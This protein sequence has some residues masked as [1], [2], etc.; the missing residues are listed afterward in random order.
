MKEKEVAGMEGEEVV[1]GKEAVGEEEVVV[2][3]V[4]EEV[5]EVLEVEWGICRLAI[6]VQQQS[7]DSA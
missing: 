6:S 3:R 2:D 1:E 7:Y 5:V 4:E